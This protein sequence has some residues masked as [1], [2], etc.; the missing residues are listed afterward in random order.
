[1]SFIQITVLAIKLGKTVSVDEETYKELV[2]LTSTL[3][4]KSEEALSIG[5]M[6]RLA[7]A[8]LKS[9][10]NNFP[11]L[12]KAIVELILDEKSRFT[13]IDEI[14]S[15]WFDKDFLEVTLGIRKV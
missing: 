10:L 15:K 8:F 9:S 12:E 14:T 3:M 13:L 11:N 1:M 6:V 5:S 4:L 2:V 7:V